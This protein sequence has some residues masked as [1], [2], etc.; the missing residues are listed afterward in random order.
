MIFNSNIYIYIYIVYII[1]AFIIERLV[2]ATC[3]N[4][5]SLAIVLG[6][7]ELLLGLACDFLAP[8]VTRYTLHP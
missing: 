4:R 6:L 5:A 1:L 3:I 8:R 7:A 2:P